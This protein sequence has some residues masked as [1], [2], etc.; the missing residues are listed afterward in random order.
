M[1]ELARVATE[2]AD[3]VGFIALLDDYSSNLSG[4]R[5]IADAAGVPDSFI[6]VDSNTAG[7]EPLLRAVSSGYVPTSLIFDGAAQ[8]WTDHIIG[9]TEGIF[10]LLF[11]EI[12]G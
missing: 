3:N 8:A 5:D 10:D 7:L 6:M 1:P 11:A 12:L 4:A 9:T 2:Y